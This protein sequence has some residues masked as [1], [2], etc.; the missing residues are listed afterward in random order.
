MVPAAHAL[1]RRIHRSHAA[2]DYIGRD[3]AKYVQILDPGSSYTDVVV[4][5]PRAGDA[6]G[7][8]AHTQDFRTADLEADVL[9]SLAARPACHRE[10]GAGPVCLKRL[11]WLIGHSANGIDIC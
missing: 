2:H 9:D 5:A 3:N 10:G 4:L 1:R 7:C 11:G 8:A 6:G